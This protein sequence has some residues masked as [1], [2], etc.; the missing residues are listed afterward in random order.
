MDITKITVGSTTYNIK[1]AN[2]VRDYAGRLY[3]GTCETAQATKAK[4]VTVS[5][6]SFTLTAGVAISV[7]FTYASAKSTM[8]IA[9]NNTT[10]CSVV[11]YG[12]T[13]CSSG[14]TTTGWP[15]G[16][17][18]IFVFD[19]TYWVR[20]FFSNTTYSAMTQA[21]IDAGTATTGRTISASL[22][23]TNAENPSNKVTSLSSAS[24]D[25][26]YPSAKCVYDLVGNVESLLSAL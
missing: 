8:T 21:E 9:V 17:V 20:S 5:D 14:T 22:F 15:A 11:Q 25:T 26:Q 1:D 19:G 4:V 10:A 18:V 12:T 16:S 3:F 24:T 6:T 7:K 2:A 13:A 23:V